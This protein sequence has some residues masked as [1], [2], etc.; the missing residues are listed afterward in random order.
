MFALAFAAMVSNDLWRIRRA[1]SAHTIGGRALDEEPA[2]RAG[3]VT[4]ERMNLVGDILG[5]AG[6]LAVIPSLSLL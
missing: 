1:Q 4:T 5:F 6:G 3:M 2:M